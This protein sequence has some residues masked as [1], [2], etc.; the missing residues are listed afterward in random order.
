MKGCVLGV[1][2]ALST[3]QKPKKPRPIKETLIR[4]NI[5]RI[6]LE[7]AHGRRDGGR[8]ERPGRDG[9]EERELARVEVVDDGLVELSTREG[10]RGLVWC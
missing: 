10:G 8:A 2:Q 4:T 7:H 9:P 6:K 5:I 3:P 1:L